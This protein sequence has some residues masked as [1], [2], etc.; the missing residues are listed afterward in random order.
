[1]NCLFKYPLLLSFSCCFS[2]AVFSQQSNFN[3][4]SGNN[5]LIS[6]QNGYA[7]FH[8]DS[9]HSPH[10]AVIRSLIIPG[11]GQLYNRQWWKAPIIYAGLGLLADAIAYNNRHYHEFLAL[12]YYRYF[13]R[14]PKSGDKYYTQAQQ[15]ANYS[16]QQIYDIK[17]SFR[18]DRDLSIMGFF[19]AWGVQMIDAY[20]DAKFK[21]SYS[22]DTDLSF[23]VT[24]TVLSG[25][26][27]AMQSENNLIIP[28]IKLTFTVQ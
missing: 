19:G 7:E 9:L 14:T 25:P 11:W 3:A 26:M 1:M 10:K 12:S 20:I 23:K 22:M 2:L 4:Q 27:Y 18:R 21:H 28:G 24:P 5:G 13:S 16:P 8:P 17:D 6:D 15:F